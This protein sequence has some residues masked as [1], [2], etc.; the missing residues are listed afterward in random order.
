MAEQMTSD[1]STETSRDARA[2]LAQRYLDLRKLTD[3]LGVIATISLHGTGLRARVGWAGYIG[4]GTSLG[5]PSGEYTEGT[6]VI[7]LRH[8]ITRELLWQAVAKNTLSNEGKKNKKEIS[9]SVERAFRKYPPET[10]RS[11]QVD[12]EKE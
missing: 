4:I 2:A 11:K 7:E 10:E 5:L 6:L 12:A 8:G 9:K 1:P 3:E